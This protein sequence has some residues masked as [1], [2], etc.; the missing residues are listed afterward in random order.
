MGAN[1]T[2]DLPGAN[3]TSDAA[4]IILGG[5]GASFTAV[6]SLANITAV[7]SLELSGGASFSSA[8]DLE[9]TGTIDLADPGTLNVTGNYTQDSSGRFLTGIGGYVPGSDFGQLN[10]TGQANLSGALQVSLFGGF[11]PVVSDSFRIMTYGSVSGGFSTETGLAIGGGLNFVSKPTT[12]HFDL[13]VL[14]SY[15]VT[16]TADSGPGSLRQAILDSNS[17]AGPDTIDFDIPMSDPNHDFGTNSWTITPLTPLPAIS[18]PTT[19]DGDS[20]PGTLAPWYFPVIVI[21]GSSAGAGADGL[22]LTAGNSSIIALTIN[23]FSGDGVSITSDHNTVLDS[24]IGADVTETVAVPNAVGVYVTGAWNVIGIT[25]AGSPFTNGDNGNAISGNSGAGLWISGSGATENVVAG[26]F[27]G[28]AFSAPPNGTDGV[29]I[30]NGATN[31]WIGVNS[32]YAA[33]TASDNNTISGNGGAGVLITGVG[34]SGNVVAGNDIGTD[35]Y[36]QTST[37]ND[38][39]VEIAA[40]AS[41]NLIGA[42]GQD[43]ADDALERNIIS[44]NSLVGVWITGAGTNNNV[45]AGDYIGTERQP[46]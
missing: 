15:V 35:F 40:G 18:V 9:N 17:T 46:A 11:T 27:L 30:D 38:V 43:G 34:T 1:S 23:G 31:N 26:N 4:T 6:S 29:L 37:P 21:N 20:Q 44:G 3:I 45:V 16:T 24:I 22:Q 19:I 32:V 14:A 41:S 12:S 39:G 7:G 42:S 36:G 5:P 8:G 13:D 28:A 2:I 33:A 25:G 10:V